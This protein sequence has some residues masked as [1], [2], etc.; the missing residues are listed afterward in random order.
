MY[1][2]IEF[3]SFLNRDTDEMTNELQ[4]WLGENYE[5]NKEI[6]AR[7]ADQSDD[8]VKKAIGRYVIKTVAG[9]EF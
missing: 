9:G 4:H 7:W 8:V 6:F 3:S 5:P 1:R 2:C